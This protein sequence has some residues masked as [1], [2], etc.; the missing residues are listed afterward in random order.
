MRIDPPMPRTDVSDVLAQ[1][2]ALR[3]AAQ[4]GSGGAPVFNP[5]LPG[6]PQRSPS[7]LAARIAADSASIGVPGDGVRGPGTS[8]GIQ[9]FGAH[10]ESAL[11]SV[12]GLQKE[13][14]R[15]TDGLARGQHQDL[16]AT[17]VASQK[18]SVAFQGALQVRNR[19]V[20][21][22]EAIMNMPI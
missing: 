3:S 5:A 19:L 21:A 18:A 12:N 22:Y 2:R 10:L 6:P 4:A 14:G 17:M 9:S 16:V 1:M 8:S 20:T 7:D 11:N 15:L 13:S